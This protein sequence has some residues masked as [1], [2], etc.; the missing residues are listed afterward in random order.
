M[1]W[2]QAIRKRWKA[3]TLIELLVVISI[4][5][6]LAA[7]LLPT[8][9]KSRD[10]ARVIVCSGNMRQV[11]Q[12]IIAYA[13]DYQGYPPRSYKGFIYNWEL[14]NAQG[15]PTKG[16][17]YVCPSMN[18]G[19]FSQGKDFAYYWTSYIENATDYKDAGPHGGV[20][21]ND[22]VAWQARRYTNLLPNSVVTIEE[23]GTD[24]GISVTNMALQG[25]PSGASWLQL[26]TIISAWS[27]N[28]YPL[29]YMNH[30]LWGNFE[31]AD[32]HV[33]KFYSGTSFST[34][35]IPPN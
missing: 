4:I 8:L 2:N 1:M 21:Y 13:D 35:W 27:S 9:A 12:L 32:G 28:N 20:I 23:G 11:G 30:S 7:L 33:Q 31:F 6:I 25:V 14:L 19:N 34:D 16:G 5:A 29:N 10:S 15:Q 26:S 24:G 17:I 18:T 22:S 3:F